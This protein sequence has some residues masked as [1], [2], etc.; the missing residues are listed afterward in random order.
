[1]TISTKRQSLQGLFQFG[2]ALGLA[3][4]IAWTIPDGMGSPVNPPSGQQ[5]SPPDAKAIRVLA[6]KRTGSLST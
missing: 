1:M 2:A 3:A 5:P 6:S 4:G